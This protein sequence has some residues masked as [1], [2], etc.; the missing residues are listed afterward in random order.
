MQ[1]SDRVTNAD[2]LKGKQASSKAKLTSKAASATVKKTASTTAKKAASTTAKKAAG[3]TAKKAASTTAKKAAG[4]TAKKAAGATAKKAAVSSDRKSKVVASG[5][6][7][8]SISRLQEKFRGV[9]LPQLIKEFSYTSTMQAPRLVKIVL[10]IGIGAEAITNS[11]AIESATR[12]L[13]VITG[14]HP[15]ITRAKKS[16]AAFKVREGMPMGITVTLRGKRM[17]EFLDKLVT[18][19]L[20]RIRDFRG[21]SRKSFDGRGN[22][23]LG[24]REQVIFPEIDY[25]SIDKMRGLEISIVTTAST[26]EEGSKLLELLGMPF[27]GPEADTRVA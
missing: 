27:A 1:G 11:K 9:V 4:A 18:S 17:Y 14:Q 26:D 20:P 25:N 3:A 7:V 23:A 5:E 22:Y 6:G 24:I 13:T 16:I 8:K 12:D 2:A 21:V 15:V 19:T 10:N